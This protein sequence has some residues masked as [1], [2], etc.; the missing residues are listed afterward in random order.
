[1]IA[2]V[3][4]K[5][6]PVKDTMNKEVKLEEVL[7]SIKYFSDENEALKEG[8]V[9]LTFATSVRTCYSN[10]VVVNKLGKCY[11]TLSIS[12]VLPHKGYDLAMFMSSVS[13]SKFL[14]VTLPEN[15]K[16]MFSAKFTPIGLYNPDPLLCNPIVYCHIIVNDCYVEQLRGALKE[17]YSL[18]P[19]DDIDFTNNLFA[20][21]RELLIVREVTE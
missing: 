21:R 8:Y 9:P 20:L 17:D 15:Q 14:D 18:K 11:H 19:I 12:D 7:N 6:T 1:M 13:V 4:L 10:L 3:N 5:E 2:C 16:M